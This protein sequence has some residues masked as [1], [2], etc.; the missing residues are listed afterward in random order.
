MET[1]NLPGQGRSQFL[2]EPAYE[3]GSGFRTRC[4]DCKAFTSSEFLRHLHNT[5]TFAPKC[6]LR[7]VFFNHTRFM[8]VDEYLHHEKGVYKSI[9]GIRAGKSPAPSDI[10]VE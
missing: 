10:V 6:H 1:Y 4:T 5:N 7:A 8:S 2:S 3:H 9:V